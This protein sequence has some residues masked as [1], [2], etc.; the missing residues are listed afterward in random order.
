MWEECLN[1]SVRNNEGE[2]RE[3]SEL[4]IKR[5]IEMMEMGKH[6]EESGWDS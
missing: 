5:E 3:I 1:E 4:G 6:F 2:R